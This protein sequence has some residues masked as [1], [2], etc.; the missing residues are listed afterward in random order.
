MIFVSVPE[1]VYDEG[2]KNADW[3]GLGHNDYLWT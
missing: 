3:P 2:N 1:T